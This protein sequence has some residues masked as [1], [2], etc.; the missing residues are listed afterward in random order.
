M[1]REYTEAQKKAT[2]KYLKESTDDIR[3]RVPKGTKERWS[4]AAAD[5]GMSMTKYVLEIV[6]DYV[7]RAGH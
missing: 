6:N 1:G 4:A 2:L 3:L 5:A 7:K